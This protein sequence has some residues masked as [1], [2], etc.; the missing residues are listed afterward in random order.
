MADGARARAMLHGVCSARGHKI[1][2]SLNTSLLKRIEVDIRH[3]VW[4]SHETN[5]DFQ[6][7]LV[8]IPHLDGK[9]LLT[10]HR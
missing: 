3:A 1:G 9:Q 4:S 2:H 7:V 5:I 8:F 6:P 10:M